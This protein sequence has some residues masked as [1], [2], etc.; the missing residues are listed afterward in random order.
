[1][2]NMIQFADA[3]TE[4]ATPATTQTEWCVEYGYDANCSCNSC[5]ELHSIKITFEDCKPGRSGVNGP[6]L[7]GSVSSFVY[8]EG[9]YT[10]VYHPIATDTH[11]SDFGRGMWAKM[12][13]LEVYQG[14]Y[15]RGQVALLT[16]RDHMTSED[17][18]R[19][20][21]ARCFGS[22]VGDFDVFHFV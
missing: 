15:M 6:V 20:M 12:D 21:K 11:A 19:Y 13:V 17:F 1:M 4:I 9:E 8:R 7:T 3:Q 14:G 2:F 22:V 5:S 16:N 10:F 18:A